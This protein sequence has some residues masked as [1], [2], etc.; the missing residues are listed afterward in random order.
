[1]SCQGNAGH[2]A[3]ERR[4]CCITFDSASF[5]K[6]IDG[7]PDWLAHFDR[8]LLTKHSYDPSDVIN[9]VTQGEQCKSEA[10][11]LAKNV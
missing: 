7:C 2:E 3:V 4:T 5:A 6:S 10:L 1:M 11:D 9:D 8:E